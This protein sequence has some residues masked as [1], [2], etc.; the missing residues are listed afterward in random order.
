MVPAENRA[1]FAATCAGA[2]AQ[3]VYLFSASA[4]LSTVIRPGSIAKPSLRRLASITTSG[5]SC[6][7]P[8]AMRTDDNVPLQP[9]FV[10]RLLMRLLSVESAAEGLNRCII[11]TRHSPNGSSGGRS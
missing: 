1:L 4:G 3:N 11:S 9:K 7:R 8:W 5:S 6:R 2:I 10:R